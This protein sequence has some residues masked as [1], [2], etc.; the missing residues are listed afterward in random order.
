MAIWESTWSVSVFVCRYFLLAFLA[1]AL[2]RRRARASQK[3]SYNWKKML[4]AS[5][6]DFKQLIMF[7]GLETIVSIFVGGTALAMTDMNPYFASLPFLAVMLPSFV[8]KGLPEIDNRIYSFKY[9]LLLLVVLAVALA[10]FLTSWLLPSL[11]ALLFYGI[12]FW[13]L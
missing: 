6:K 8:L 9:V 13:E 7:Y 10:S 12:I 11:A 4:S 5:G 1:V 2:Y 3:H